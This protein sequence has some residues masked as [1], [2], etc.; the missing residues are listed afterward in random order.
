[1]E[2][3]TSKYFKYAIGEI[4]LVVIGILIALQINNWNTERLANYEEQ[5]L[6]KILKSEFQYNKQ[7]LNRNIQKATRLKNRADS[8][9]LIFMQP[10]ELIDSNRLHFLTSSMGAYSTFDPS[11]GA[12]TNLISSGAL[13]LI[14]ND[15]LRITLSKWFGEVQD[16][17]EDEVRLMDFGDTHLVPLQLKFMNLRKETA[18]NRNSLEILNNPRFENIIVRMSRGADYIVENYKLLEFEI[19][20]ILALLNKE[21]KEYYD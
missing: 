11:N 10:K 21:I 4:L 8:L 14:K 16:V 3:K 19:E 18:F 17:K 12:L 13:N 5:K 9:L 6:L 20:K 7:E 2:N 1:M 15:S